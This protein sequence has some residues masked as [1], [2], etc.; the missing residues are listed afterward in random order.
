MQIKFPFKPYQV[1]WTDCR[2][3]AKA[4]LAGINHRL[5]VAVLLWQCLTSKQTNKKRKADG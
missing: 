1:T 4:R 5:H 2:R 3:L